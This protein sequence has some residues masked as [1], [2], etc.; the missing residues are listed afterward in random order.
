MKNS[1]IAKIDQCLFDGANSGYLTDE[2]NRSDYILSVMDAPSSV[3]GE[4]PSDED[5][6]EFEEFVRKNFDY[7]NE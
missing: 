1:V 2:M 4:D 5:I 6:C 7:T 3:D